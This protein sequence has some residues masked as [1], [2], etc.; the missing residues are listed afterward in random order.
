[1]LRKILS[2]FYRKEGKMI[3]VTPRGTVFTLL[4][5]ALILTGIV[6][7]ITSEHYFLLAFQLLSNPTLILLNVL[8][9]LLL[10]LLLFFLSAN[11]GF[12]L[13][14]GAF[15]LLLFSVGDAMKVSMRQDP[16]LPTDFTLLREVW[17]ILKTFPPIVLGLILV[18][19]VVLCI[20][21]VL[22]ILRVRSAP[23][24]LPKRAAGVIAVVLLFFGANSLW[25]GNQSLYNSYPV[26]GN[27]YFQVDQYNSKGLLYS[28]LLN[29]NTMQLSEPDGYD[30]EAIS[31]LEA[32]A[33]CDAETDQLPHIIMIM[34]E[35]YSDLSEN[36]HLDFSDYV[37]PM[38][39]FRALCSEEGAISGH[40]VV[41]RFGGGTSD[42]EYDVLTAC[43]TR[44][45]N[46]TLPSYNFVHTT[47]DALPARLASIGYD[48]LAIHPGY[49][50]FY[51][52]QNVYPDFGFAEC[53]FL[54]NAFD[55]ATQNKGG[56]ISEEATFDMILE[57][58]QQ[59]IEQSD[60]PLFSFTVTIQNH[61]P[62]DEKYAETEENFSC[63]LPLTDSQRNLLTQ[64]FMG[65]VDADEQ[66]GRLAEYA[67]NS[68]EP[69]VIVYFGDHLPG[70]SNGME[71]FSLLDYPIDSNG[72]EAEQLA[73]YETPYLI[74]Q[75]DTAKA[76]CDFSE[77]AA[78]AEL[79][80]DG[81][82]SSN[83]LGALLTELLEL[84][85]LSPLYD[86]SNEL[87][88]ELPIIANYLCVDSE[89]NYLS[90][91]SEE[92]LEKLHLYTQWQYYKLF[93]QY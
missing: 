73:V 2:A 39:N 86:F 69:I 23:L 51:N 9:V 41:P 11:V 30:A 20:P 59:Q 62:Y 92:Q 93:D 89:G 56:Y 14:C 85:G 84:D 10:L 33:D 27:Q 5:G 79:P 42:T 17:I 1:M 40:L 8:V 71:F 4:F 19:F 47:F 74:W 53:L 65:I 67:K 75:N 88:K 52:R 57:T 63:D 29:C 34:G 38:A 32:P 6:F 80:E 36:P 37:D 35:A 13:S 46:H 55:A 81:L 18:L 49:Q 3:S 26:I 28:F 50:W 7:L 78:D 44:Y 58:L 90:F 82:I 87:R 76:L 43:S 22:S 83:Y 91:V 21:M 64:Y 70:F 25:F 60:A 31:A 24:S 54:E 15:V 12:S 16:V 61:G 48:T 77:T 45:L 68:E 66:L 72:T